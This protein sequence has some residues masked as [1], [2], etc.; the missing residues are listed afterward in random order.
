[1][2]EVEL[3]EEI[4]NKIKAWISTHSID[5]TVDDFVNEFLDMV[6]DQEEEW[7]TDF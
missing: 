7:L 1:M 3:E 2:P 4:F 6:F 5:M